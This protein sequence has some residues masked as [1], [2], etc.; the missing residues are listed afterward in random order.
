MRGAAQG[1]R[2]RRNRGVP[3]RG[4]PDEHTLEEYA[5]AAQR[6]GA[7]AC[8]F[9]SAGNSMS[10]PGVLCGMGPARLPNPPPRVA[11]TAMASFYSPGSEEPALS[12]HY[13]AP[14][15]IPILLAREHDQPSVT[16]HSAPWPKAASRYSIVLRPE[17][18]QE[19]AFW[20]DL[21]SV[22]AHGAAAAAVPLGPNGHL[23]LHLAVLCGAPLRTVQ[24][25]YEAHPA[26]AETAD[27]FGYLPLHYACEGEVTPRADA[28]VVTFLLEVAP[29]TANA[30]ILLNNYPS[31]RR[32]SPITPLGLAVGSCADTAIMQAIL[33]VCP[34]AA[35][36]EI[37]GGLHKEPLML[38]LLWHGPAASPEACKLL[39]EAD[40]EASTEGARQ[41]P[42][43]KPLHIAVQAS[44]GEGVVRHLLEAAP[45]LVEERQIHRYP[46]YLAWTGNGSFGHLKANPLPL[47]VLKLLAEAFPAVLLPAGGINALHHALLE[48][49]PADHIAWLLGREPAA[50]RREVGPHS[51]MSVD[52][53]GCARATSEHNLVQKGLALH[54]AF[55]RSYEDYSGYDEAEMRPVLVALIDANREALTARDSSGRTPLSL[56][57]TN[58]YP[59]NITRLVCST[60]AAVIPLGRGH[61]PLHTLLQRGIKRGDGGTKGLFDELLSLSLSAISD[62]NN[63]SS[64][65]L[66]ALSVRRP[67][68]PA[69]GLVNPPEVIAQLIALHPEAVQGVAADL[70]RVTNPLQTTTTATT[71]TLTYTTFPPPLQ[72]ESLKK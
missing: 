36:Q 24:A 37:K 39:L 31:H 60:E 49:A 42:N 11:E 9:L 35:T 14:L 51:S 8:I 43:L 15:E 32:E 18:W 6:G 40:P 72:K 53:S 26:A 50:A 46:F 7:A 38:R 45:A 17:P 65:L 10:A 16:Q 1:A 27:K 2:L 12:R 56:A 70:N 30:L 68:H 5:L 29:T 25:V 44:C 71:T 55:S 20:A 64:L 34:T 33:A 3:K 47:G 62:G 57:L 52:G 61:L 69:E 23:P 58:G 4:E 28:A 66:S 19:P 54:A 48:W 13:V 63:A 59:T 21:D 22:A 41:W 67:G